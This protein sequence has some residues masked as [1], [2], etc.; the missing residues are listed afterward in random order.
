V[1]FNGNTD[2]LVLP[3]GQQDA[4]R[5]FNVDAG[6]NR[7]ASQQ[8]QYNLRTLP[9]R[10][11]GLRGDDQHRWDLSVLKYFPIGERV[12]A[13]FRAEA[14]NALNQTNFNDPQMSPVNTAFGRITGT[15]SQARTFQFAVKLE[16]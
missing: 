9:F 4:D 5:W 8:L 1:I 13:Q 14:F 3:R 6:L 2:E 12:R 16:F 7:V 11:S 10:F 15:S